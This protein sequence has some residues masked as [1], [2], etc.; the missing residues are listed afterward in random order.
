MSSVL[1]HLEMHT[2]H[3]QWTSKETLW[4]DE[5]RIWL[6][7]IDTALAEAK[8]LESTLCEHRKALE[9]HVETLHSMRQNRT[10]HERALAE[11][12]EGGQGENLIAMASAHEHEAERH[13]QLYQVHERVKRHHH[14]AVAYWRLLFKSLSKEM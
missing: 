12:E 4:E 14:T 11:F 9:A 5:A 1:S 7:E 6:D 10:P 3:K 13:Y 8:K 2:D